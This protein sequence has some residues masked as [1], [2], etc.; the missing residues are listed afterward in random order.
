MWVSRVCFIIFIAMSTITATVPELEFECIKHLSN[1]IIFLFTYIVSSRLFFLMKIS[2]HKWLNLVGMELQ[3]FLDNT[4]SPIFSINTT[5][6]LQKQ[7]FWIDRHWNRK[8]KS[9]SLLKLQCTNSEI[10]SKIC[11][12][13]L[14]LWGGV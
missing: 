9:F 4:F 12:G 1:K 6:Y 5:Y 14:A 7:P 13:V 2:P 10:D 8:Y 3:F 11:Y